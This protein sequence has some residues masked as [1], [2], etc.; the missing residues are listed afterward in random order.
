MKKNQVFEELVEVLSKKYE[1][2]SREE[3]KDVNGQPRGEQCRLKCNV[4]VDGYNFP[5]VVVVDHYYRSGMVLSFVGE[6][7]C[8]YPMADFD[9]NDYVRIIHEV[10]G[11]PEKI[12]CSMLPLVKE[13]MED[14]SE[15]LEEYLAEFIE[16]SKHV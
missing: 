8:G 7:N 13:K 14:V 5:L 9:D 11:L 12:C 10:T 2:I 15:R 16:A 3:C 1:F 4:L 6:Y